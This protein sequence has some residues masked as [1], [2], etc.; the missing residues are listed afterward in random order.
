MRK[1]VVFILI[2]VLAWLGWRWWHER[3]PKHDAPEG[4]K[5]WVA[6]EKTM[7]AD[8]QFVAS[9]DLR[10]LSPLLRKAMVGLGS[11][12]GDIVDQVT[13]IE[14]A[15][16]VDPWKVLDSSVVASDGAGFVVVF[17]LAGKTRADF[18]D[19]MHALAKAGG[20]ELKISERDGATIYDG[21]YESP[22]AVRWLGDDVFVGGLGDEG[23]ADP[24]FLRRMTSGGIAGDK[25]FAKL[26]SAVAADAAFALL[27]RDTPLE[28]E[29]EHPGM[30]VLALRGVN[31]AIDVRVYPDKTDH[32]KG[33]ADELEMTI[34]VGKHVFQDGEFQKLIPILD[35]L[36]VEQKSDHV[37]VAG[38]VPLT[39]LAA[40][41]A[42]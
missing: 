27:V 31:L 7:P 41:L 32:L 21:A 25:T 38:S 33:I 37:A 28:A 18:E 5:A 4:R 9:T 12:W 14:N 22:W 24:A 26:R 19:C 8:L 29:R 15:C 1:L 40:A 10:K 39:E 11:E 42:R 13:H 23:F 6:S 30:L 2:V 20:R 3:S 35:A 17:A 34:E 16:R 36:R